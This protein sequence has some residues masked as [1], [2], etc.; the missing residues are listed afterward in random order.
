MKPQV[1]AAVIDV[2]FIDLPDSAEFML[3]NYYTKCIF[4]Y[5]IVYRPKGKG[6]R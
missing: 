2:L 6:L 1:T 5:N 3:K 4:V